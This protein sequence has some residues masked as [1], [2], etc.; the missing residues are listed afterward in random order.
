MDWSTPSTTYDKY[1]PPERFRITHPFH[2]STGKE[3]EIVAW[4]HNWTEDRVYFHGGKNRLRS[5]PASWTNLVV[6]DPVVVLSNGRLYFRALDLLD[7][8]ELV[9]ELRS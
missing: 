7:L 3:F 9:R 4:H 6:D 1:R 5:V 2:P 8:A